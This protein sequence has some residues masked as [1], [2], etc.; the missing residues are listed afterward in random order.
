GRAVPAVTSCSVGRLPLLFPKHAG[1]YQKDGT[2][3]LECN[4]FQQPLRPPNR[5]I[6]SPQLSPLEIKGRIVIDREF[7]GQ[8]LIHINAVGSKNSAELKTP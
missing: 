7:G 8:L 3:S 2:P 1:D 6:G 4:N 5:A